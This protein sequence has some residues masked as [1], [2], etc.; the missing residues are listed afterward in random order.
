MEFL[1]FLA[2]ALV[3]ITPIL[4]ISA[5]VRVQRLSEQLRTF[6]LDKVSDRLS[7]LER[8]EP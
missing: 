4:A 8:A 3:I 2:V 7:T 1:I 5:F 6:P